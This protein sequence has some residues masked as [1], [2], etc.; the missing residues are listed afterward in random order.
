VALLRDQHLRLR[1]A[2]ST[3]PPARLKDTPKG[4][5]WR[6]EQYIYGAASHDLYHAGQIQVL[7]RLQKAP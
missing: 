2:V 6:L 7:K 1:Q 3:C 5:K 4:L